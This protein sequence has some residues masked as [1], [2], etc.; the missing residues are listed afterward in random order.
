MRWTRHHRFEV[1]LFVG[2][3]LICFPTILSCPKLLDVPLNVVEMDKL[4]K[5]DT[6]TQVFCGDNAN[7]VPG[8]NYKYNVENSTSRDDVN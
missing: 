2:R 5:N 1:C 3:S 8:A 4:F 7:L 6:F